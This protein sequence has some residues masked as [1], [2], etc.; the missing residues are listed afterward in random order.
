M[1]KED[2]NINLL[3]K[4]AVKSVFQFC[5]YSLNKKKEF[6]SIINLVHVSVLFSIIL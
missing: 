1:S 6:G 3:C 5:R 2:T 4:G